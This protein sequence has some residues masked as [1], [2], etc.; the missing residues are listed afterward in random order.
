MFAGTPRG[1]LNP[2]YKEYV[3]RSVEAEDE[4]QAMLDAYNTH[5]HIEMVSNGSPGVYVEEEI[6]STPEEDAK[7]IERYQGIINKMSYDDV[8]MECF[9]M[10]WFRVNCH[11][12]IGT[13][14]AWKLVIC[15]DACTRRGVVTQTATGRFGCM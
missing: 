13:D 10:K 9:K 8:A 14:I 2:L 3:V 7:E 4:T 15:S 6:V 5:N 1:G 12:V 11:P